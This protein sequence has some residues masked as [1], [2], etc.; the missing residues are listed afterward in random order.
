MLGVILVSKMM[1]FPRLEEPGKS[2]GRRIKFLMLLF[3]THTTR[4]VQNLTNRYLNTEQE[5]RF[6]L[7]SAHC[8]DQVQHIQ[9]DQMQEDFQMI[10]GFGCAG[11]LPL[12]LEPLGVLSLA[13]DDLFKGGGI[14]LNATAHNQVPIQIQV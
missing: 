1:G 8:L 7:Q 4:H 13:W 12:V 5:G 3:H 10:Q 11:T 2:M 6:S 9:L 14:L